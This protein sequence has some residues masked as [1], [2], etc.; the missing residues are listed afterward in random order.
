MDRTWSSAQPWQDN[1]RLASWS[2]GDGAHCMND[3]RDIELN[4][5]EN[6]KQSLRKLKFCHSP[7]QDFPFGWQQKLDHGFDF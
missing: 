1:A 3:W 6:A 5:F 4:L 2:E 7:Q